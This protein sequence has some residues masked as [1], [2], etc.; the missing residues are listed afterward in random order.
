MSTQWPWRSGTPHRPPHAVTFLRGP[1]R[2]GPALYFL[3]LVLPIVVAGCS[4]AHREPLA[5]GFVAYGDTHLGLWATV[6]I[7]GK[8]LVTDDGYY[9]IRLKPGT[10]PYE[11]ATLLGT[12]TGDIAF[13]G[14][15]ELRIQ[16]PTFQGWSRRQFD[17][18]AVW[19]N[20]THTVRWPRH[21][22]ISVWVHPDFTSAHFGSVAW[23]ALSEWQSLLK[24]VVQFVPVAER[25]YA[26]LTVEP[27]PRT[28]FSGQVIGECWLHWTHEGY[29]RQGHIYIRDD[30]THDGALLRHETGH[31][32]GLGH[33]EDDRHVMYPVIGSTNQFVTSTERDMA[34]LL[35]SIPPR[36]QRFRAAARLADDLSDGA[37]RF[38]PG[39]GLWFQ[40]IH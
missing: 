25:Q 35:Y 19:P 39:T 26:D 22:P 37:P 11:V 31:C 7:D 8:Q 21:R 33:S 38:D 16:L 2:P 12:Q 9:A 27:K 36:T 10:H 5:R 40:I 34:R 3:V 32:I 29:I 14:Q 15:N 24:D 6:N 23:D 17:A 28:F 20:S 1:R 13:E 18:L 30:W 4:P